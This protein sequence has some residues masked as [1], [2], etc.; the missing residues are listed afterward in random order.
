MADTSKLSNEELIA[1]N[2]P[3]EDELPLES[4]PTADA[5]ATPASDP[6]PKPADETA[7]ADKA[8]ADSPGE[9][10]QDRANL[11]A[12]RKSEER[13]LRQ[14]EAVRKENERLLALIPKEPELVRPSEEALSD[15]KEY[16]PETAQYIA[17]LE[18]KAAE[19]AKLQTK[20]TAPQENDDFVPEKLNDDPKVA[21]E[22]QELVDDVSDLAKWHLD[23]DQSNWKRAKLLDV[24]LSGHPDWQGKPLKDRF[25]EVVRMR[26]AEL[27]VKPAAPKKAQ[28]TVEEAKRV[29]EEKAQV[30]P[31]S[32]SDLKGKSTPTTH[33]PSKRAEWKSMTNEQ[34]LATLPEDD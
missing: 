24:M 11:R 13:A 21:A 9:T 25:Q 30:A 5:V 28:A 8:S 34:L 23:P 12:A 26:N 6:E 1:A 3:E 4:T 17:D 18:H 7:P 31:V 15:I 10:N 22:L 16:A 29:I 27:G 2:H 19:F 32:I 20:T 33:A 14:L